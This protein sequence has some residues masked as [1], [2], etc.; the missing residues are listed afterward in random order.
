MLSPYLIGCYFFEDFN[1][2]QRRLLFYKRSV[3]KTKLLA[4]E[5]IYSCFFV[6]NWIIIEKAHYAIAK[7]IKVVLYF[8]NAGDELTLSKVHFRKI[9]IKKIEMH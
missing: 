2:E 1:R 6:S 5:D 7:V 4:E 8:P 3:R 9:L